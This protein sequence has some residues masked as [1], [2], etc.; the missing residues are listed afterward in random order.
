[1]TNFCCTYFDKWWQDQGMFLGFCSPALYLLVFL[2]V[3]FFCIKDMKQSSY[4]FISFNEKAIGSEEV[5]LVSNKFL[6][7]LTFIL[8]A[9]LETSQMR[10]DCFLE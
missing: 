5:I 4:V 9:N 10:D 8:K 1:M 6:K 3:S 7:E 2:V